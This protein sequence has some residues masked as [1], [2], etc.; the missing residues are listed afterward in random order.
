MD[1]RRWLRSQWDRA[2]AVVAV[3]IGAL[4]LFFGYLGVA[5]A[6]L[7]AQQIP[8]LVSGGLVGMFALG[9]GATMW[10]SAD[11]RDEWRKLDDIYRRMGAQHE[12]RD[13]RPAPEHSAPEPAADRRRPDAEANGH[14]ARSSTSTSTE[15][16]RR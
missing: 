11:L 15:T 9:I 4:A 6:K 10:L 14:T 12:R 7:P 16:A 5:D 8:Y 1:L 2:T 13:A 3:V